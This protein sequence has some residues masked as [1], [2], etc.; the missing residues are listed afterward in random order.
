[1]TFV[2]GDVLVRQ[3]DAKRWELRAPVIYQGAR[4]TFV[5]PEN[6][7]TDFASIPRLV[8][9]LIPRYG[10]YTRAAILHDYLCTKK[11]VHRADADGLFR[12]SMHE[13]G[14]SAPRRWMMWAAV[15]AFSLMRRA[16]LKQ[17]L[18]FLV[19]APLS[20]VFIAI[21]A[22][23]VQAFLV[24]FWVVELIFWVLNRLFGHG[25]PPVPRLQVRTA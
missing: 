7:V 10:L 4:D 21:P 23:V 15:R 22:L 19:I 1:M 24:L 12:R 8:V 18:G 3:L 20:L 16:D 5:V 14:V 6:F 2:D 9:W 17:W 13:L 25:K 11:P